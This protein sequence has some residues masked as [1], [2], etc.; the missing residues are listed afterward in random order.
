MKK[1]NHALISDLLSLS[2]VASLSG[3]YTVT[4]Q[5]DN[6]EI[7]ISLSRSTGSTQEKA[8]KSRFSRQVYQW[9]VFGL[10]PYDFWNSL[11][12]ETKDLKAQ[13][14][15]DHIVAQE[16][17]GSGGVINLNVE[18]DKGLNSWLLGLL[19]G[20]IPAVGPVIAANISVLVEGNVLAP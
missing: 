15:V 13:Q 12:P 4:V 2:L 6:S 20:L 5:S 8:I 17:A 19:V 7:P 18:T 16:A 14:F 1:K 9:Y 10:L 11:A 3:C